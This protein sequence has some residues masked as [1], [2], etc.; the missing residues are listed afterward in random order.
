M[1]ADLYLRPRF[2]QNRS[3]WQASLDVAV[4]RPAQAAEVSAEQDQ[5]QIDAIAAYEQLYGD[6]GYF[7]DP[8]NEWSVLAKFGLSW[9]GDIIPLLDES[10]CLSPALAGRLLA[11]LEQR[12][13][14]FEQALKEQ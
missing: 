14:E 1:G 5:A 12:Q 13:G 9:W 8:Y 7:R 2:E 4:A 6:D 11:M 10:G 3:R